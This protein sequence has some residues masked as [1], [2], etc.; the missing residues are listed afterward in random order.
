MNSKQSPSLESEAKMNS[1]IRWLR[2]SYWA[3]AI[4]DVYL[5]FRWAFQGNT[6]AD[7]YPDAG[8]NMGMKYTAVLALSWGILLLWADRKPQERKGILAITIF[9]VISGLIACN[10]LA[11]DAGFEGTSALTRSIVMGALIVLMTISY[12]NAKRSETSAASLIRKDDVM[13]VGRRAT[14]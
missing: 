14:G 10:L 8:Y 3:G 12:L 2:I 4:G 1:E 9:P 6:M 7:T 11:F 5:A 13:R